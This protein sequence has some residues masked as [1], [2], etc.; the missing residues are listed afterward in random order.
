MFR[1]EQL[2]TEFREIADSVISNQVAENSSG[3]GLRRSWPGIDTEARA[4]G[5][6]F[7]SIPAGKGRP[8][9]FDLRQ[10]HAWGISLDRKVMV[11]KHVGHF[12][13]ISFADM[14]QS[15]I[16][17]IT[18]SSAMVPLS[19]HS[20]KELGGEEVELAVAWAK[21]PHLQTE[22]LE[23]LCTLSAD[24]Q[25]TVDA[26]LASLAISRAELDEDLQ[27]ISRAHRQPIPHIRVF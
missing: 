11:G 26:Q 15:L 20:R 5:L 18:F 22:A 10:E 6:T 8:T 13:L 1:Q 4:Y 23:A 24:E 25:Q 21:S 14:Q 19:V 7:V 12:A 16:R 2:V 3:T 9:R 27:A 17:D